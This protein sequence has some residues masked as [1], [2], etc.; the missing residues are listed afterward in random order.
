MNNQLGSKYLP[1]KRELSKRPITL[2][3]N[4][5]VYTHKLVH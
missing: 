1:V 5:D 4:Y 2:F 3:S